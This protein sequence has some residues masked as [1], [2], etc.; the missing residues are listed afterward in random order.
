[1]V[2]NYDCY[3][4]EG[5]TAAFDD[6]FERNRVRV[7]SS[8]LKRSEQF[9]T[10]GVLVDIGPGEGRYLPVWQNYF[11]AATVVGCEF[12]RV[13]TAR[14]H[15]AN[16]IALHVVASG[17]AIPLRS[18][19]VDRLVT[20]E[21]IEHV[22]D[23]RAMLGECRRILK[24]GGFAL[25]STPCGNPGSLEWA[26][27]AVGGNIRPSGDDGVLFAKT[28]DPTHLRRYRSRE[29]VALSEH[30]GFAVEAVYFNAHALVTLAQRIEAGVRGRLD[31][32]R[33]SQRA[34][35]AFS[36]SIDAL[37]YLDWR[38]LRGMPAGTTMVLL[39]RRR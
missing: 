25:V 19:S 29:F 37:G 26:M 9:S 31:I 7:I 16:P 28:E 36:R 24:P 22:P 10:N 20:I 12:S 17:G 6:H 13:A 30:T 27:N 33:R 23:G 5:R 3:H 18:E 39:L 4:K 15:H 32:A 11:P 1:M 38:L 14:S 8:I 35:D 34:S 21:V 2:V